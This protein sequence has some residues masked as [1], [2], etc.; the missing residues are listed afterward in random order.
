VVAAAGFID[1]RQRA[2]HS[3]DRS[4]RRRAWWLGAMALLDGIWVYAWGAR[5][6][7]VVV[8]I[9][10]LVGLAV[11]RPGAKDR[12]PDRKRLAVGLVA[13]A[14]C[15]VGLIVGLRVGRDV[16][17]GGSVNQTISDQSLVRQ[18]SIAA[19]TTSYDAFV[20]AVRDWPSA[21]RYR[22]GE[23]F[24]NGTIG[25]VPRS[26]WR[27]KPDQ[28]IPGSWFRQVYE[29]AK[30]NGW[31][32]GVAG[33]W[34]LNWGTSGVLVGGL[35]SGFV[36]ALAQRTLHRSSTNPYAFACTISIGLL[37]LDVGVGSQFILRWAGFVLPLILL[38][39]ALRAGPQ[40][41]TPTDPTSLAVANGATT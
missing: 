32:M 1:L 20:L 41:S 11:F 3:Q 29:P 12:A 22:D 4:M 33:E 34:Y 15:V 24:L 17:I 26:V 30:R 40:R 9:V 6:Q 7:F 31:P 13:V 14:V 18:V 28:I 36:V 23:D 10:A 35:V 37:V 19:N 5:S 38:T 16:L 21:H 2:A 25:V 8:A 39:Y 27:D